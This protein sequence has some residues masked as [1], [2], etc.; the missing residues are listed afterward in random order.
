MAE[1]VLALAKGAI[2]DS[3]GRERPTSRGRLKPFITISAFGIESVLAISQ[4][5]IVSLGGLL[6]KKVFIAPVGCDKFPEKIKYHV[7]LRNFTVL[8][9]PFHSALSS[10]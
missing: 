4:S 10:V 9:N 7:L 2:P 6:S 3:G 1:C 8:V 5:D